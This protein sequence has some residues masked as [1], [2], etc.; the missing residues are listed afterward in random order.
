MRAVTRLRKP[1]FRSWLM[2]LLVAA[3]ACM[4]ACVVVGPLPVVMRYTSP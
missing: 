3:T 4:S 1:A 2:P